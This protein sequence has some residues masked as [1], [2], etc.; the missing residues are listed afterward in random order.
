MRLRPWRWRYPWRTKRLRGWLRL[1][2]S[3]TARA[4]R[5][6][7]S[8]RDRSS[9]NYFPSLRFYLSRQLQAILRPGFRELAFLARR[10]GN[11]AGIKPTPL[12]KC[13]K[14]QPGELIND[15]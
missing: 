8:A 11:F 12:V 1:F 13:A 14:I 7:R 9:V 5:P 15:P 2:Y 3:K 6:R 10:R 4:V